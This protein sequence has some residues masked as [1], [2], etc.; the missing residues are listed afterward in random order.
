MK[1]VDARQSF[2]TLNYIIIVQPHQKIY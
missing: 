1:Q 2:M